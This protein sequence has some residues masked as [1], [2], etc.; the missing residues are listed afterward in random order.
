MGLL[1][2]AEFR[3]EVEGGLQRNNIPSTRTNRWINQALREFGYAFKFHELET[4]TA[5]VTVSAQSIYGIGSDIAI[6][7]FRAVDELRRTAPEDRLGRIVPETRSQYNLKI[8]DINNVDSYNNPT[9]YH[10]WA[11]NI[12]FRPIPDA[13]AVTIIMD[14]FKSITSLTL[15]AHLSPFHEDWDEAII[16]GALYRGFRYFGEYDRYQNVRNDFLGIVRSRSSEMEL[17][18]F[19]EG[20]INPSAGSDESAMETG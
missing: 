2:L 14:Y 15:D 3:S 1:T 10:R 13:T 18:E 6:T 11:N 19:P 17:E 20:S 7:N 16:T 9:H 4:S 8:G 12:Y 5:F